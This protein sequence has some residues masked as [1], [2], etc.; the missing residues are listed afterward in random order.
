VCEAVLPGIIELMAISMLIGFFNLLNSIFGVCFVIRNKIDV[1][2]TYGRRGSQGSQ[3]TS[4]F[5]SSSSSP[6]F[7]GSLT[8]RK[9]SKTEKVVK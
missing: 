9:K 1:P 2:K 3:R 7:R 4:S 5:S 6:D 8:G